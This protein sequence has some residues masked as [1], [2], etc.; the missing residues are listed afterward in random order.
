Q[1]D[2]SSLPNEMLVRIFSFT[3]P[4]DLTNLQLTSKQFNS[5]VESHP[6]PTMKF[7]QL[8]IEGRPYGHIF[9]LQSTDEK[10]SKWGIC[11]GECG[12]HRHRLG[13]TRENSHKIF[14]GG[15]VREI[16]T[17]STQFLSDLESLMKHSDVRDVSIHNVVVNDSMLD[18][19][20]FLLHKKIIDT[21][22]FRNVDFQ[23]E[24]TDRL[25]RFFIEL[26]KKC[27]RFHRIHNIQ[28]L[29]EVF[30]EV[31]YQL[32]AFNGCGE[33]SISAE[34]T[35]D[36]TSLILLPS[37]SINI[38][39]SFSD[40]R[41]PA[42]SIDPFDLRELAEIILDTQETGK[43][44]RFHFDIRDIDLIP[45]QWSDRYPNTQTSITIRLGLDRTVIKLWRGRIQ[46]ELHT[47]SGEV[48]VLFKTRA[49]Q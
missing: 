26:G 48:Q 17:P 28:N 42:V 23:F 36:E 7:T 46:A 10:S 11:D 34:R 5:I 39:S 20:E 27:M 41:L 2:R 9:L 40:L 49:A 19:I 33:I 16:T 8:V 4:Q 13:V 21:I 3:T 37:N 22:S 38:L 6:M 12:D 45:F 24:N 44:Y 47:G 31:F 14:E 43:S 30:N 32:A 35:N 29:S 18:Y 25:R 15:E 1:M